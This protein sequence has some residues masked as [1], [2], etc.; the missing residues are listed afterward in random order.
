[1]KN[2]MGIQGGDRGKMHQEIHQ[3]LADLNVVVRPTLNILDA[4]RVL[5]MEGPGGGRKDYVVQADTILCGTSAVTV[6]AWGADPANLP[7]KQGHH[8][9]AAVKH[10]AL[11][12]EVGLGV[13]DPSKIEVA[14]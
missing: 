14:A 13:A 10:I 2:L 9:L 11:G 7:W 12:A 4:T 8:D 5:V 6:D 3:N 1:M